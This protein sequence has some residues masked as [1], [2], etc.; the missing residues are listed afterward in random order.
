MSS[1]TP[2]AELGTSR[3]A[4][5]NYS[6]TNYIIA[7]LLLEENHRRIRGAQPAHPNPPT[8]RP[9]R[10]LLRPPARTPPVTGFS[11]ILPG[12]DTTA[13]PY[14]AIETAAGAAGTLVSTAP[15]LATFIT[16]LATRQLLFSANMLDVMTLD[17][18]DGN[19]GLG[20]EPF[21]TPAGVA[22]THGGSI[23]GFKSR[24][25]VIAETGDAFIVLGNDDTRNLDDLVTQIV[26]T[27]TEQAFQS[28]ARCRPHRTRAAQTTPAPASSRSPPSTWSVTSTSGPWSQSLPTTSPRSCVIRR[29]P[30]VP[31]R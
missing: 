23:P 18:A 11:S 19:F 1:L 20:I 10:H 27:G 21:D 13:A 6:N 12:G 29:R 16:A 30:N 22:F 28:A 24:I 14:T 25:G 3:R 26:D 4:P 2:P 15:D 9:A 17:V 8:P 31:L 5:I 7:G